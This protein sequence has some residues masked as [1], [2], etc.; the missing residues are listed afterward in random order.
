[1]RGFLGLT[2]NF[3]PRLSII[4]LSLEVMST[5]EKLLVNCLDKLQEAIR[6]LRDTK[7]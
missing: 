1:L 3:W 5:E 2:V 7:Q 6:M 4:V